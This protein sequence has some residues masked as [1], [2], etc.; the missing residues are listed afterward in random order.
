M[1]GGS[2]LRSVNLTQPY[3]NGVAIVN[4][5]QSPKQKNALISIPGVGRRCEG[6]RGH[7]GSASD[8]CVSDSWE[9]SSRTQVLIPACPMLTL[10]VL[11]NSRRVPVPCASLNARPTTAVRSS[12]I[13]VLA[14]APMYASGLYVE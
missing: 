4:T 14:N 12:L 13:K 9:V 10:L 11:P 7:K 2:E 5:K 1:V 8:S 6:A 3:I